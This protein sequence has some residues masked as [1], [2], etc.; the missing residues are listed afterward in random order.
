MSQ[1]PADATPIYS[2]RSA[3]ACNTCHVEPD[4]WANP[5]VPDRTCSLDCSTC[6][7]SPTG[8]GLRTPSG[9]YYGKEMLPRWGHRPSA[10]A[11]PRDSEIAGHFRLGKGFSGWAPGETPSGDVAHRYGGIEPDPVFRGGGDVRLL[12]YVPFEAERDAAFFP[13]QAELY[14]MAR[15][16]D[17]VVVY[18]DVGLQSSRAGLNLLGLD[19]GSAGPLDYLRVRELFVKVDRLPMNAWVRAGRFTPAYGW[20]LPDHTSFIRRDLGFDQNRQVFGVEGGINPNYPY[21]NGAV[22]VQG[23]DAWP[24]DTGERGWGAT[25]QGGVRH[26]GWQAGGNLQVL[27]RAESGAELLIGPQWAVN[28]YPLVVLGELDLRRDFGGNTTSIAGYTELNWLMTWGLSGR[29]KFDWIDPDVTLR[30]DHKNRIALGAE[31]NPWTYTQ[32][33][34]QYRTNFTDG[35]VLLIGSDFVG[36]EVLGLMHG[37]L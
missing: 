22:F 32:V 4:D 8:G 33:E 13:M 6:H 36:H 18:G 35:T 30:G 9:L 15:P 16:H 5:A 1:V 27:N 14:L 29:L 21:V 12:T 2:V 3:N 10:D 7:V 17:K 20:R 23:L 28:L 11:P 19:V 34:V 31:F 25:A 24:G 37:W 26:L